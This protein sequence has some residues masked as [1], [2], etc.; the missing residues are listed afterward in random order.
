MI[1]KILTLTAALV[2]CGSALAQAPAS[3]PV[4]GRVGTVQGLVTMSTGNVISSVTPGS[5]IFEGSRL[6]TGSTGSA[7][8]SLNNGCEMNLAPNQSFTV[9]TSK[10]C[11]KAVA[12]ASFASDSDLRLGLVLLTGSV[13]AIGSQ[14]GGSSSGSGGQIPISPR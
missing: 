6:V 3:P 1:R 2:L 12:L 8:L 7:S 4:V 10:G 14:Q 5:P 13:L 11:D 9:D